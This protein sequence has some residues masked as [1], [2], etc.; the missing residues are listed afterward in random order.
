[1]KT[2]KK[3]GTRAARRAE[4]RANAKQLLTKQAQDPNFLNGAKAEPQLQKAAPVQKDDTTTAAKQH[5]IK[6]SEKVEKDE[7]TRKKQYHES[8]V[9]TITNCGVLNFHIAKTFV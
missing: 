3:N 1:M 2:Y 8:M 9:N 7:D 6:T 5:V 4:L